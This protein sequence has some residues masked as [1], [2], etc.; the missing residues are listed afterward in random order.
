MSHEPDRK[1]WENCPLCRGKG[2]LLLWSAR[3]G[4]TARCRCDEGG[5]L[6]TAQLERRREMDM[7][8]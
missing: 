2:G 1:P 7:L 4:E 5:P 6:Y 3:D 8:G